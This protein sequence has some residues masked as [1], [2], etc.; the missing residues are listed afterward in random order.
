MVLQLGGVYV[1][2]PGVARPSGVQ[3]PGLSLT[4]LWDGHNE[5]W[6]S[7]TLTVCDKPSQPGA[8]LCQAAPPSELGSHWRLRIHPHCAPGMAPAPHC[9]SLALLSSEVTREEGGR[10]KDQLSHTSAR[11]P[12]R[13]STQLLELP[14]LVSH[15]YTLKNKGSKW[16]M[17]PY[18]KKFGSP[19]NLSVL[20]KRT[21]FFG[22]KRKRNK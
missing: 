19:K 22:E 6:V 2:C 14:K 3:W 8:H 9:C 4:D 20:L 16:M 10:A 5:V 7:V 18:E 11:G 17:T 21:S 12:V 15:L 13:T 1:W